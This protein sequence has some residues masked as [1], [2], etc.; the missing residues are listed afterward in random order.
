MRSLRW[1][2]AATLWLSLGV[3]TISQA[4]EI[5]GAIQGT[6]DPSQIAQQ[7]GVYYV[8]STADNL[9]L[10]TSTDLINWQWGTKPFQFPQGIP[11]W[12]VNFCQGGADAPPWNL[13][14]PEIVRLGTTYYLYYSRNCP[15]AGGGEQSLL[16]VATSPSLTAPNWTDQGQVLSVDLNTAHYRVIDPA[17]LVDP[18]NRVWVAVGSFGS[19]DALGFQNGG[20][21]IFEINPSTGKLLNASDPGTRL[22]GSWIEAPYL[23]YR[24]GYYYLYFNQERCC[25]G[26]NSRYFIRIGRSTNLLGPYLDKDGTRLLD[27]GG[28]LFK[29]LD[30]DANYLN[31]NPRPNQGA[32]GRELGPGHVGIHRTT[33]GVDLFTYHFYDLGTANG[34]PTMGLRALVYGEDG[35]PR[36]GWN[37]LDGEISIGSAL[38]AGSGVEMF[39]NV[40]AGNP[41]VPTFNVWSGTN[42]QLWRMERVAANTYRILSVQTG[43]ALALQGGNA[44]LAAYV[45]NGTFHWVVRQSNDRSFALINVGSGLALQVPGSV[46]SPTPLNGGAYT[47]A[48]N[49]RQWLNPSGHFKVRNQWSQLNASVPNLTANTQVVQVPNATNDSQVWRLIPF[50]DGYLKLQNV[51]SG[52]FM[53]LQSTANT[54]GVQVVQRAGSTTHAQ[55]WAVEPLPD[56]SWRLISRLTEKVLSIP[57]Q[58]QGAGAVQNRWLSTREQQWALLYQPQPNAST[59]TA[60]PSATRS[61]TPSAT[62]TRTST[63]TN[64][65]SLPTFTASRTATPSAT[66]TPTVPPAGGF[67]RGADVGWLTE[68]EAAGRVFRDN[69]GVQRDLFQILAQHCINSIRLRVWVNPAGGWNGKA[70]VIA[71]AVRARNAGMRVMIDFHY[72]DSWADPGQQTKPAAWGAYTFTQLRQ[73]VY[74]HT[75]DVLSGLQAAGVTPEWVQVGNETNDGMLWNDG[76]A[77]TNMAQYAQ[78]VDRGYQAVKDVFPSAKVVVHV[79]NGWDNAL[80][81]WNIGG[82]VANGARFD[83]I[84]MSL[85]PTPTDWATVNAQALANMQDMITRFP[86]KEVAVVEVGMDTNQPTAAFNFLSDIIAKTQSLPSGKG[87]GVFYWEP[88]SYNWAGYGKAVWEADGSP[89]LG[90]DA[91]GTGCAPGPSPTPTRTMTRTA[92]RTSTLLPPTVTATRTATPSSTFTRTSTAVPLTPTSTPT[93]TATASW[94]LTRT[95]T[96]VPPTPSPTATRTSTAVPPT[97]TSSRTPTV[98][99]TVTF[100][101]SFTSTSVPP[102]STPTSTGTSTASRTASSATATRTSTAVP[103]TATPTSTLTSSATATLTST[104]TATPSSTAT[105]SLTPTST[106]TPSTTLTRTATMTLSATSSATATASLTASPTPTLSATSSATS[107][108]TLSPTGTLPPTSTFTLSSTPTVSAT[109]TPTATASS[110]ATATTTST[111]TRTSTQTSTPSSTSTLVFTPTSTRTA[112]STL[113]ATSSAT[114]TVTSTA[115]L[116]MTR[117]ATSTA[118][119]TASTT[120]TFTR[121]STLTATSSVTAS[122]TPTVSAT[123]SATSTVTV[124][125]SPT[126]TAGTHPV[127]FPNPVSTGTVALLPQSYAGSQDVTVCLYTAGYKLVATKRFANVPL[128][129]LVGVDLVDDWGQSLGN[130]VYY[131]SVTVGRDRKTTTL[132]LAR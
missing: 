32:I 112:T 30:Y 57:S 78:L 93:R 81:Q 13:W 114:P 104:A 45:N 42:R 17:V 28:T 125:S 84:G 7:N 88:Q 40:D 5:S 27:Q 99:N 110:T 18:T 123:S 108:V 67:A 10:K 14:A 80:F 72:S 53:E 89:S 47:N 38:M 129:E 34:E 70:D 91:F 106:A 69:A 52:L 71:K 48:P 113:S 64:T 127:V 73:A 37:P 96:A 21:R 22:A 120:P 82:L 59:P 49:Q 77:S 9:N 41:T 12:M 76:R 39:L 92:T 23:Q 90:M 74:D 62:P 4:V 121:T 122:P 116:T 111:L 83:V 55:K 51:A 66:S 46:T 56:G 3:S 33:E 63:R 2:L 25:A 115:S 58:A 65:P 131:V 36:F 75:V 8:Y 16:G 85:Y 101:P 95:S 24:N 107:T 105:L 87:L 86:G 54:D 6:H 29:G 124:T 102:T 126:M 97:P 50:T 15:R 61:A 11:Q 117:T 20:I 68:M 60:T 43:Q 100:T 132:I 109:S 118:S 128:G 35:W 31:N 98:T 19:P 44:V 1:S 103:P 26:V 119:A 130:G 94:T 79:S